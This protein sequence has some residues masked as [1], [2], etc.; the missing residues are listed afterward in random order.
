M[1]R[2]RKER[3]RRVPV[4]EVALTRPTRTLASYSPQQKVTFKPD[5]AR[6][7]KFCTN[8]AVMCMKT[9]KTTT[10][11]PEKRWT[12][13]TIRAQLSDNLDQRNTKLT[14]VVVIGGSNRRR[15]ARPAIRA[16]AT[17][18]TSQTARQN[19]DAAMTPLRAAPWSVRQ[20]TDSTPPF[21]SDL[22][23]ASEWLGRRRRAAAVQGAFGISNAVSHANSVAPRP[24]AQSEHEE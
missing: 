23:P 18:R 14:G 17:T 10:Y 13:P 8:E 5:A 15:G 22:K 20:L 12:F 1:I 21:F 11:C 24:D 3:F 2:F 6:K 4:M 7:I 16:N 9:N 19:T